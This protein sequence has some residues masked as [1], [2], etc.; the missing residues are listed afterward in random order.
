MSE[1]KPEF[2]PDSIDSA[3]AR[4]DQRLEGMEARQIENT[5]HLRQVTGD[6]ASRISKLEQWKYWVVGIATGAAFAFQEVWQK[7]T[8]KQ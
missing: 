7:L 3:I 8:G 2:N 4:I 6:H 5:T 1:K